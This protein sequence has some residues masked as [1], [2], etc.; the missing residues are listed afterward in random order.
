MQGVWPV[1]IIVRTDANVVDGGDLFG[2]EAADT[3]TMLCWWQ[4]N[5]VGEPPI[6][7]ALPAEHGE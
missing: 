1:F 4:W 7:A 5:K 6:I 2:W 3:H